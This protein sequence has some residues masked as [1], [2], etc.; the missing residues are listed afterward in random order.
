MEEWVREDVDKGKLYWR[1][2]ESEYKLV[3]YLE[4][5]MYIM[6][7]AHDQLGHRGMY[8]TK[9]L[10]KERFWWPEMER[11]I[12]WYVGTCHI[13]QEHQK[14]VIKAL[15]TVSFTPSVFQVLHAD[16]MHMPKASNRHKYIVHGRCALTSWMEGRTL[17]SE[18]AQAIGEWLFE[19]IICRWGCLLLIVM[20]NGKPFKAA[21]KYLE[22]KYGIRGI[23]ILPYNSQAN[24]RIE[25]PHWDV[26]Q[27][28][29]KVCGGVENQWHHYFILIMWADRITIRKRM[30]C[31]PFFAVTGAHLVLPLDVLEATWLVEYPGRIVEDWELRGLRAIALQK[32]VDKVEEMRQNMD[33]TKRERTLQL[34]AP[35]ETSEVARGWAAGLSVDWDIVDK[36]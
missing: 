31:S 1:D 36:K 16:T 14:T 3:I 26:W 21:L 23:L 17:V 18:M 33:A 30:G 34:T 12:A 27:A 25:R 20:D 4:R 15:P 9:M 7:M 19:D 8:A 13:C 11:D 28:L 6:K 35:L 10:I 22:K 32:H 29:Y 2:M 5:R 24:G